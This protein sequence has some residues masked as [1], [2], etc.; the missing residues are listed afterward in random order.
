MIPD[1]IFQPTL[2]PIEEWLG[3][4]A[5]DFVPLYPWVG[6]VLL[7][8]FLESIHFHRIPIKEHILL[9]PFEIMGKHSLKIY[10]LHQPIFF[11]LLFLFIT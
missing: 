11:G 6:F 7:G 10:L 2:I 1:F 4:A 3:V 8:I 5:M 9:K